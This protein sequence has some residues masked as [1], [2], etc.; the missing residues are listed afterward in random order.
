MTVCSITKHTHKMAFV[1][2]K[3]RVD[4]VGVDVCLFDRTP[5]C[6]AWRT[7]YANLYIYVSA[8]FDRADC[9]RPP[10]RMCVVECWSAARISDTVNVS[11]SPPRVFYILID[12]ERGGLHQHTAT[13]V[14]LCR[15]ERRNAPL[16]ITTTTTTL[17][18]AAKWSVRRDEC[19]LILHI[20][21]A[22]FHNARKVV[23]VVCSW[24]WQNVKC[25]PAPRLCASSHACAA[26]PE[27]V[28]HAHSETNMMINAYCVLKSL[29]AMKSTPVPHTHTHIHLALNHCK[30]WA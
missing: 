19:L 30:W 26:R 14:S 10:H 1:H 28:S 29:H 17:D 13:H 5:Q 3:S 4:W 24:R 11:R 27:C 25:L 22:D 6:N 18:N 8:R 20:L 21:S 23:V 2:I 16:N 9:K 7:A 12:I 15:K